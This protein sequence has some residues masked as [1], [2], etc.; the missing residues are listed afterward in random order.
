MEVLGTLSGGSIVVKRYMAS[1]T[2]STA[3]IVVTAHDAMATDIGE[4]TAAVAAGAAMEVMTGVTVDVT[5]EAVAA[6]GVEST[7]AISV[8]VVVNPDAIYRTRMSQTAANDAITQQT[9]TGASA[10]GVLV[11]GVTTLN[12]GICW[13]FSGSNIGDYRITDGSAAPSINWINAV[14][15]GDVY[16][17]AS[18]SPNGL[19]PTQETWDLTTDLTEVIIGAASADN[20]N[21][22]ALDVETRGIDEDGDNNSYYHMIANNHIFGGNVQDT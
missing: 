16:L 4:V 11:T 6:T 22:K 9:T 19:I 3:G 12:E 2:M 7:D 14:A 20:D 13:G 17:V 15:I 5:T 21:F 18:G 10:T 1:A 8:D